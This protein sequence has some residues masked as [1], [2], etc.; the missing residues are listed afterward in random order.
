MNYDKII[1]LISSKDTESV[2]LGFHI[3]SLM[4][5]KDLTRDVI[6]YLE[7]SY[8]KYYNCSHKVICNSRILVHRS[9]NTDIICTNPK[10]SNPVCYRLLNF[11]IAYDHRIIRVG[12]DRIFKYTRD[13]GQLFEIIKDEK[14]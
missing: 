14:Y 13:H 5:D 10:Q 2:G 7:N 4:D 3:I 8:R 9:K 11:F 6:K 1:E 12:S